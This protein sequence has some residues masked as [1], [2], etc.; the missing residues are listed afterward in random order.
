MRL[1]YLIIVFSLDRLLFSCASA[2]PNPV[3]SV[4][5]PWARATDGIPKHAQPTHK[6]WRSDANEDE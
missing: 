1:F 2:N 3:I 6:H 5:D 4:K